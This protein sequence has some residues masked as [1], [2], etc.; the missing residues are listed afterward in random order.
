M[1][2]R[3]DVLRIVEAGVRA[4]S[5]DNDHRFRVRETER[6]LDVLADDQSTAPIHRRIL[7]W[8]SLGAVI[9]NMTIRAGGLGYALQI[10]W[11]PDPA[12]RALIAS[13]ELRRAPALTV[14]LDAAIDS[15]HTNR[16]LAFAGPPL[17]S[18][19]LE[20]FAASAASID[21]VKLQWVEGDARKRLLRMMALAESTRFDLQPLH[22]DLFSAVRFD[23]G[24]HASADRGLPPAALQVEP[25]ARWAF[26]QLRRWP[27]MRLLRLFGLHRAL[28]FRAAYVPARMAPHL[29]FLATSSSLDPH[30]GLAIGRALERLWLD[31]EQRGLALQ[32]FAAAGLLA[33]PDYRDVPPAVGETLRAGW[34][35]LT[36]ENPLIVFRLG[37]ARRPAITTGRPP[38]IRYLDSP[39]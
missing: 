22:Q 8:V 12:N 24:W 10:A 21:G 18:K 31:V 14:P 3:T 17:S 11:F 28:G 34:T 33:Q 4:P 39:G 30:G 6:G 35:A 15:R 23:V 26:S 2:S 38:A 5:A 19:E 1:L 16:A 32:P 7:G 37:R 9:E 20:S 29:G 27:V 25:G 36:A 13:L